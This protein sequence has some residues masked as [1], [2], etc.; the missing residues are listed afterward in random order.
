MDF[1]YSANRLNVA[2]SRAQCAVILAASPQLFRPECRTVKQMKLANGL[3]R[4]R[5]LATALP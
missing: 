1:L 5:E 2:T 4:F 3:C